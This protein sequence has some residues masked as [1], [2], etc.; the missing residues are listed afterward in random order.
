MNIKTIL[1]GLIT[2]FI[3]GLFGSGG[4]SLLVP[5]L[6][7]ILKIEEHKSHATALGIIIFFTLTSSFIYVRNGIYDLNITYKVAIG[8]I[9]G[10]ILGA[11][12]L[13]K[14]SGKKLRLIFGVFMILAS[15]RMV[16]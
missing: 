5:C 14:C 4:G 16:F 6:N 10:G 12:L 3:N 7:N 15:I 11:K 8:S 9:V 13:N 2:G 1:I